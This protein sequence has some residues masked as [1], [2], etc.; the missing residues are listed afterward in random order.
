MID[1]TIHYTAVPVGRKNRYP[2]Q[3]RFACGTWPGA[4]DQIL[5]AWERIEVLEN[6]PHYVSV[7]VEE[8]SVNLGTNLCGH[9]YGVV[10]C[11]PL[12]GKEV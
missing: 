12:K 5:K 7:D 6:N 2:R 3:Y 11:E 10:S 8:T 9:E 1:V 4:L